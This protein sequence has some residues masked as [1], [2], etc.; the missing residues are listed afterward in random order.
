MG[1]EQN[2]I[3][4]AAARL[5]KERRAREEAAQRRWA[6]AVRE[7]PQLAAIDEELRHT[8]LEIAAVAFR[9][10]E[11]DGT[12][13][14]VRQRNLELQAKRAELLA[15]HGYSAAELENTPACPLCGDT[16]WQG[17][18][19]C[20]C[21]RKLCAEEQIKE[22]SS[23]LDLGEQSF[24]SFDLEYYSPLPWPGREV[25]PRQNMEMVREICWN[26][27]DKFGR[28]P[29]RNLFLSG[30]PG[31]GKTFLSA[32]IAKT[33]A[34]HG[35]SVVYDTAINVFRRFEAEKFSKDEE[36]L[37]Q[38]KEETRRYLRCDL[39]ILDDLGS[40][41]TTPFVQSALY[42]LVNERLVGGKRTVISSNLSIAEVYRRYLPQTA[43]RLE[44]EYRALPF[45]G[46]DVR[47][48]KK[49][50]E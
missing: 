32:C 40:E 37:R 3:R 21:L 22:L 47:L 48:Q 43:S 14:E 30:D 18:R 46:K 49:E 26:Y 39:L 44:G 15:R 34:E 5:E 20:S 8:V 4:R 38:A 29:I 25:T 16:G 1:Y 2:V 7:I 45:F 9:G 28:F 33:V 19:M 17:S 36:D 50:K 27:A 12:I 13:E 42:Q 35:F 31:L 6:E 10:G 11:G 23:L 41:L 24:D